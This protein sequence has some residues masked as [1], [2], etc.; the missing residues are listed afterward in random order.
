MPR[1]LYNGLQLGFGLNGVDLVAD[2]SGALLWPATRTLVVADLHL[3]KA[4]AFAARGQMLPPYDS[5]E[6]LDRLAAAIRRTRP[7]RVVCLGD[8]FHDGGGPA[9]LGAAERRALNGLAAGRD[10]L[11]LTGNHD[12]HLPDDLPGRAA[13]EL[14][15]GG[16][17]LR[18]QAVPGAAAEVSGHFH[19]KASVSQRGTRLSGRCFATDG[20][21]LILPA[22]GALTGG[23]S[24]TA[25]PLRG[26][27]GRRFTVL[28]LG[29]RR[30]FAIPSDR[31]AAGEGADGAAPRPARTPARTRAAAD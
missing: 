2:L 13:A 20:D 4:S 14:V 12:P 25:P 10:W 23:L 27:L 7:E 6:T 9:R 26:L 31:L 19:P 21:K 18:H 22:F 30:L 24:V 28:F 17:V 15:E 5:R 1:L 29:E 3:E 11:W 16:L 8:S